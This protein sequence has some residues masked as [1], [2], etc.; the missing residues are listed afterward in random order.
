MSLNKHTVLGCAAILL[1]SS[2]VALLRHVSEQ[3]GPIGGAALVYSLSS[4]FLLGSVGTPD[5]K[6]IPKRYL[7]GGGALFVAYETCMALS[8]GFANSRTQAIG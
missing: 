8:L 7:L 3:F 1:W 4:L 2:V 5:L 6:T